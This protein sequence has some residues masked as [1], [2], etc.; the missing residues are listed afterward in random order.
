[1]S[2]NA[3]SAEK[4]IVLT[5]D[6]GPRPE[7][8][9]D[10]LPLLEKY[11]V[12][13]NFFMIG[14]E[15]SANKTFVK[16]VY[17]G[18][19]EIEN[20]GWGH[21]NFK[22]LFKQKGATAVE[23]NLM[24][25]SDAIFQAIGRRPRFFRPPFWEIAPEIEKI[26]LGQGYR[27]MKLDNPDINT[28]DYE[29][30]DKKRSSEILIERVKSQIT[31]QE[32]W[33]IYTHVL[34]FHELPI[35]VEALK[36]LIPYFQ[37]NGYQFKRLDEIF[38]V[39]EIKLLPSSDEVRA[40]YLGSNSIY[41]KKKIAE[42]EKI[43]STTNANGI[44]IDFKDS[45]LPDEKLIANLVE[46]FKKL[47]AY[48]IA[49]IV[50]FQD[51]YFAKRHS[52]VAIKTSS[53]D[54]WWSGK[55]SWKRYWLDPASSL[56]QDYNIEI[57]KRAIDAGF[58]EIQFDYIRFPTDG[59]MKDIYFPI[60]DPVKMNKTLVMRN[61]FEKIHRELKAYSPKVSLGIDVF[62]E[63]FVYGG[64]N[65]IGQNII[66]AADYFDVLCP[67]AYPSHYKCGEFGLQ[68]PN[69]H[70]YK[71][72]YSTLSAGLRF[73]KGKKVIIRPWIQDFTLRNI[74]AC[75]PKIVYTEDKVAEGIRAG[76]DL[77]IN[78]FMLWNVGSKFQIGVFADSIR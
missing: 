59:N 35:A 2:F 4:I 57:A 31:K 9:K 15:V 75:G 43:I 21:E 42:L 62:G 58:D 56:A 70:P 10:L 22:K 68:D 54:F 73:L 6:D 61:F 18:G 36:N 64:G 71:T 20:H 14:A 72:Y 40:V 12:L 60:F 53:G 41:S 30:A 8:L 34:V 37:S 74:Y 78:G 38:G 76:R 24:K 77:G 26:I 69:A 7:V 65:S 63:V 44:V 11:A 17:D 45:N 19:H 49:R 66:N 3:F 67:M 1:V 39:F 48:T 46:R 32:K 27:V 25:A 47:N 33:N 23:K 16:K 13:A 52:E 28:M 5:F 55:K 29:D 51:T 50:V